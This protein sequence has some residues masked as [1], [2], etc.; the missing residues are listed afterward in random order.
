MM[1]K[2]ADGGEGEGM[3]GRTRS[4]PWRLEL[5]EHLSFCRAM[6]RER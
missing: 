3:Q 5:V 6:F 1:P 4:V 2:N